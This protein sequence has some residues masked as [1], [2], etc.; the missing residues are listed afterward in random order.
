MKQMDLESKYDVAERLLM[1]TFKGLIIA[2]I[3]TYIKIMHISPINCLTPSHFSD[4]YT[5]FANANCLRLYQYRGHPNKETNEGTQ[6]DSESYLRIELILL[7]MAMLN[8]VTFSVW[9][10][11]IESDSNL[12]WKNGVTTVHYMIF[13]FV[14]IISI[15][16][17]F[18]YLNSF[19]RQNNNILGVQVIKDLWLGRDFTHL[20]NT[21]PRAILCD[22]NMNKENS[23]TFECLLPFNFFQ[24]K[25]VIFIWF[26]YSFLLVI[27]FYK[28]FILFFKNYF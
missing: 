22:F 10:T 24:E 18:Y 9:E 27:N 26:W 12:P 8:F 14:N 16:V 25:F 11:C 19:L 21:F 1:F 17:Q 20:N 7:Y 2:C 28:F 5:D 13:K 23:L 15:C 6:T 3:F 4:Y